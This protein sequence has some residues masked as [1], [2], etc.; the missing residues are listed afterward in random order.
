MKSEGPGGGKLLTEQIEATRQH[1]RPCSD[2]PFRRDSLHG[3]LGGYLPEM[4][5]NAAHGEERMP[6]HL[7]KGMQC[8]GAGIFRGNVFKSPRN[9]ELLT[10]RPDREVVFSSTQE[11][12]QHHTAKRKA[13]RK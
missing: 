11:F 3:W 12:I 4:F 2:C 10:L 1:K 13:K 8:A 6:C 7:V 5:T 9:K